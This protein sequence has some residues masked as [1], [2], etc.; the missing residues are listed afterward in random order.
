VTTTDTDVTPCRVC[1]SPVFEDEQYCEACGAR[2]AV[3]E[4]AEE[5]TAVPRPAAHREEQDQGDIASVSDVGHRRHRNED[6]AVVAGAD[7]RFVAVVCDGVASTANGDQAAQAAAHAALAVLQP[8]LVAPSWPDGGGLQELLGEAFAA[9]QRAVMQVDPDEPGGNDLSPSTTMV[10]AIATPQRI[11]VGNVGDS[12]AYWLSSDS[13]DSRVLTVDDS[14][15]QERIAE[16]APSDEAYADPEAHIITRWIG[17]DADSVVPRVTELEV[18]GPGYLVV[19]SD[20]LWHYFDD[21]VRLADL[22]PPGAPSP[23]RVAR[24][25]TDAGLDAGG[26]DNITVAVVSLRGSPD[27]TTSQEQ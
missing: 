1:R 11:V 6:A 20:G 24:A 17:G 12:R 27:P 15:A 4:S 8:L 7:G 14:W 22:I 5:R 21:P 18:T 23:M 19:C 3:G 2:V 25:L 9:A 26:Q 10:A 16:G 13:V